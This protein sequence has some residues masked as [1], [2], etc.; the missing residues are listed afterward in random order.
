MTPRE[1][2]WSVRRIDEQDIGRQLHLIGPGAWA[3]F[4]LYGAVIVALT[5]VFDRPN[6]SAATDVIAIVILLAAALL[7]VSPSRTPIPIWRVVG[8]LI[9]ALTAVATLTV[10]E[11]ILSSLPEQAAWYQ[12]AANFLLFGLALRGRVAAAWIGEALM[13]AFVCVWSTTLTGSPLYGIAMSYGQ[14]ISLAA[15]TI[16][17]IALLATA[18]RII[19][20][21]TAQQRRAALE[22]GESAENAAAEGERRIVRELAEPTLRLIAAGENPDKEEARTLEAA[23]RDLIRGRSLAI[24]PLTAALGEARRRRV[25]V[26]VLDDGTGVGVTPQAL[27]DAATWCAAVLG[28]IDSGSITIRL[29]DAPPGALVTLVTDAGIRHERLL[30]GD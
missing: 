5:Y 18:R 11:P 16:F 2:W 6:R 19:E 20:F 13:I 15:G 26:V 4:A 27:K 17:A 9:L 8:V 30:I 28:T 14:P 22:A 3:I 29:A 7:I 10:R 23:L 21:R 12:A 24:E 25:D 1:P